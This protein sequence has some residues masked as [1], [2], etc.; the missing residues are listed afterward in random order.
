MV[1]N[2]KYIN[3]TK[4]LSIIIP[5][6]HFSRPLNKKRFFMPK[7]TI[8]ETLRDIKKNVVADYE[9]I[10]VC[11][12]TDSKLHEYII[13]NPDIDRYCINSVNV[14]VARS[15]NIGAQLAEGEVLCYLN[16]DVSV[17]AGSLEGLTAQL[18]ASDQIGEIGPAGSYWRNCQHYSFVEESNDL[19]EADV[20][21]GF[22]FL[23]RASTFHAVGGFDIAYTPAGFEEI[24]L[25]YKIRQKGLKCVVNQAVNIRHYHHHGVSAQK[26]DIHYLGSVISTDELH[27]RNKAYFRQKWQGVFA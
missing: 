10:V 12:G 15:W 20:V 8:T 22:C 11:N 9:V 6:L 24:D 2:R 4:K 3:G 14:G 21:S 17:G 7:Q 25:S 19:V 27:E 18:L 13:N 23:L 1:K 5:V 26:V 16:D